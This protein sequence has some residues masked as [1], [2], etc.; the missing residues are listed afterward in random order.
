[1]PITSIL[2]LLDGGAGSEAVVRTA[3]DLGRG[4]GAHVE[5][6]Y[7]EMPLHSAV[8][9][10]TEGLS[11]GMLDE[12]IRAN[13]D[14]A[15]QRRLHMDG[16][17]RRLCGDQ[18]IAVSDPDTAPAGEAFSVARRDVVGHINREIAQRGRLHD[19]IVVAPPTEET[20]GVDSAALEAALFDTGRPVLMAAGDTSNIIG[21][22]VTLAWDGSREAALAADL[23]LPILERAASVEVL[24]V[25]DAG[26]GA[27]PAEIAGFLKRHAVACTTRMLSAGGRDVAD[28]LV[29]ESLR[30]GDGLLVMGAFGHSPIGEF[31]FGGVTRGAMTAASVPLLMAH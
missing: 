11:G 2:A 7:V 26:R 15:G 17:F 31:L 4:F 29:E 13:K 23:A 14:A 5:C 22:R 16:V 18:G 9:A 19:L 6:L 28:L 1:M 30:D 20:G 24:T 3:I 21:A 25:T 8:P 27:D 12:L 10:F